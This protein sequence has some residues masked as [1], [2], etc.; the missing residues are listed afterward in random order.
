MVPNLGCDALILICCGFDSC[1]EDSI[2]DSVDD[3]LLDCVPAS[4]VIVA[5]A[6]HTAPMIAPIDRPRLKAVDSRVAGDNATVMA[7]VADTPLRVVKW[8][9]AIFG[10][11]D[12]HILTW[13][14]G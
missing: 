2:D 3:V 12:A 1:F 14:S 10:W 11:R 6:P 9:S 7:S 5:T 4:A 13:L 8:R